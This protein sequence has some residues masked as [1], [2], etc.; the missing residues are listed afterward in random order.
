MRDWMRTHRSEI[1]CYAVILLL[2]LAVLPPTAHYYRT[3]YVKQ[4]EDNSNATEKKI[5]A[6]EGRIDVIEVKREKAEATM[7]TLEGKETKIMSEIVTRRES[8]TSLEMA[9]LAEK[10]RKRGVNVTVI[11]LDN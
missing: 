2:I 9:Q 7:D 10:F 5:A 8:R 1:I 6:S 3:D 4:S 11:N